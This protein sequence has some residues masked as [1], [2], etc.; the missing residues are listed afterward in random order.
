MPQWTCDSCE[1]EHDDATLTPAG[2][3][4]NGELYCAL[5]FDDNMVWVCD[6]GDAYHRDD[7]EY[8]DTEGGRICE[9]CYGDNYFS[10]S[11]CGETTHNEDGEE[12]ADHDTVCAVCFREHVDLCHECGDSLFHAIEVNEEYYCAECLRT[13]LVDDMSTLVDEACECEDCES[14]AIDMVEAARRCD[15]ARTDRGPWQCSMCGAMQRPDTIPTNLAPLMQCRFI[16][17]RHGRDAELKC[18]ACCPS[19]NEYKYII[20]NYSYKPTPVFRRVDRDL[21]ERSLHFGTEV[22]VEINDDKNTDEAL[23]LIARLDDERLFYCKAD[24]CI[25]DG[26]ELVSHPFTCEWMHENNEAFNAMFGLGKIMK[27]WES[28]N[29][30]MHVHMSVDAFSNLQLLKFMRFFYENKTFIAKVARRPKGKLEDWA[31]M[32]TPDSAQLQSYTRRKRGSI[33]VGRGALNVEGGYTVECRI[34]RSTLAPTVYYGNI[35]FLQALFDYTK[36]CGLHQLEHNRFLS[37]V[38]D[39]ARAYK[40]FITL[41]STTR[42]VLVDESGG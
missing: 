32:R 8:Y 10:C 28:T 30:G 17:N 23:K 4:A 35:E 42:P 3:M 39:R 9:G 7:Y 20:N 11:S 18:R 21:E 40:N 31:T 22:E 5:C 24:S 26:F 41:T 14:D 12:T 37:F 15:L 16:L 34:F 27:G 13:K 25:H 38:H 36:T 33:G 1:R 29:C 2:T 6:C 19:G